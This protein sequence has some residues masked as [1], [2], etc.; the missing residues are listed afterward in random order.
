MITQ[1]INKLTSVNVVK[2]LF[3]GAKLWS[4]KFNNDFD[5][6]A[7]PFHSYRIKSE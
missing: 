7:F 3:D 4:K 6:G 1:T 5:F 2:P